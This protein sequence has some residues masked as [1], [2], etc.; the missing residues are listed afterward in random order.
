MTIHIVTDS[1]SDI[2]KEVIEKL[3][4]SVVPLYVTLNGENYQDNID[5]TRKRFYEELPDSDP[6]PTT[7]TPSP[8]QFMHAYDNAVNKGASAIFSIHVSKTLSATCES[9]EIAAKNYQDVT[10][11]VVDSGNLTL[12]EGL[13]VIS[14]AQAAKAGQSEEEVMAVIQS[15]IQRSHA[16]AKLDTIDYLL[17]GGADELHSAQHY[18][19]SGHKTDP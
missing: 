7:A 11:H 3:P 18:Q 5:L 19:R 16:Y 10:V 14:A 1:T 2:P 13:V 15:T 17:R 9:A 4:I 12:A 8:D 6:Y